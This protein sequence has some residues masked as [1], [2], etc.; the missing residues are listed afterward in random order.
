MTDIATLTRAE[1]IALADCERVIEQGLKT[2][3]EV[4]SA[5]AVI[6]ESGLY[7]GTHVTFEAYA[8]DRW[9][10]SRPRAY[11]LMTAA[12]VVS[13]MPDTAAPITSARQATE[14]AKVPEL[15]RA[16]VW[17]ETVERTNGKPTAAAVREVTEE[18][19]KR[20]AEQRD[21]REH[22]RQI[23]ELAWS[24]NWPEGHVEHWAKQLGPYDHELS[25]LVERATRAIS[26]LD[27]LIEGSGR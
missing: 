21:A 12:E 23:V 7:R 25:D 22:L 16:E 18:Q 8:R 20:A 13:G 9:N 10:L 17:Q 19:R 26:V 4:G 1:A 14:L 3:V 2:F 15:E 27:G 6:R 11:E 24:P 5:L